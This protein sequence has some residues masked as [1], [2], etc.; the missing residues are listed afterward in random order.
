M[1]TS[2]KPI[3][4]AAIG[5][6]EFGSKITKKISEEN[7]GNIL[8]ISV[9]WRQTIL[10]ES[11]AQKKIRVRK[12]ESAF[13]EVR[14]LRSKIEQMLDGIDVVFIFADMG[15]EIIRNYAVA[16]S[17]ALKDYELLTLGIAVLPAKSKSKRIYREAY[18]NLQRFRDGIAVAA[19]QEGSQY[20]CDGDSYAEADVYDTIGNFNNIGYCWEVE[21]YSG[22]KSTLKTIAHTAQK[23]N[24]I[25]VCDVAIAGMLKISKMLSLDYI[26]ND[27]SSVVNALKVPGGLHIASAHNAVNKCEHG[28]SETYLTTRVYILERKLTK[29]G[30][31]NTYVDS[32]KSILI[33]LTVPSNTQKIEIKYLCEQLMGRSGAN[34][35]ELAISVDDTLGKMLKAE[36]IATDVNTEDEWA[37]Y[38]EE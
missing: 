31:L 25:D 22:T 28:C 36:I 15:E 5:M 26:G 21:R 4:I 11:S 7:K 30:I 1:N 3:K 33:H 32:A 24:D 20:Y 13:D 35:V 18:Y 2:R 19:F 29:S 37:E 23:K 38:C 27:C 12:N 17:Y 9:D 8:T 14:R 34:Q 10:S 16:I 6:G